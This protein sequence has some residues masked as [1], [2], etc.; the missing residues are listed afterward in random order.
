M[1]EYRRSTSPG[2]G[3]QAPKV[4]EG[5]VISFPG[6]RSRDALWCAQKRAH[7]TRLR[8]IVRLNT[9]GYSE[10]GKEIFR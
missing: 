5:G 6:I 1:S 7:P 3:T 8:F 4:T 10:N 2:V 9:P